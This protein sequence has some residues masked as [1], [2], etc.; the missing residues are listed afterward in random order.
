M[1]AG[2]CWDWK[3]KRNPEATDVNIPDFGF[4]MK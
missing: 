1:V 2:Y 4:A 3:S